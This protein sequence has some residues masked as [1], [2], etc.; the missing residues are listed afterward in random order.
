MLIHMI[1]AA[2]NIQG[3]WL[4]I[5]DIK[6][7]LCNEFLVAESMKPKV[8]FCPV[9]IRLMTCL[10]THDFRLFRVDSFFR[11]TITLFIVNFGLYNFADHLLSLTAALHTA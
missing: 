3:I 10:I 5:K 8:A 7:V 4:Y 2:T 6:C 9:Q 1:A 11:E